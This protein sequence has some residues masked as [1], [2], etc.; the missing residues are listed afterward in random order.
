MTVTD[1]VDALKLPAGA[2]VNKR[3]PKAL[4]AEYGATT[5]AQ[6]RL[7]RNGLE[8]LRWVAA[9]KPGTVGTGAYRDE[10]REYL[11]IIVLNVR[12]RAG[13][14]SDG[15]TELIHRAVPYPI[16]LL[17]V[18]GSVPIISTAHKRRSR[19]V[20]ADFTIDGEVVIARFDHDCSSAVILQFRDAVGLPN[21]PA[22]TLY[23]LY[24]SWTGIVRALQAAS[25]T[26]A[27]KAPITAHDAARR[28]T[29]L[30][31]YR[32][33]ERQISRAQAAATKESQVAR[34]AEHNLEVSHLRGQLNSLAA[35][36]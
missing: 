20:P 12:F 24:R 16:L 28:A 25:I 23:D 6:R 3:V 21:Q 33:V 17:A 26:G 36:L 2:I 13:A 32:D 4:L 7:I 9:L 11:E 35:R 22:G 31:Q 30:S 27:F 34:R 15:L 8:E 14:K 10:T 19:R 1:L 5:P 18:D 29:L